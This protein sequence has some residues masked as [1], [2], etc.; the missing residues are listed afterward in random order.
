MKTIIIL[1]MLLLSGC[2]SHTPPANFWGG[3]GFGYQVDRVN[4]NKDIGIATAT[5]GF[6]KEIGRGFGIGG[7]VATKSIKSR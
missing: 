4:K 2:M 6:E 7:E 3:V 1:I 5:M